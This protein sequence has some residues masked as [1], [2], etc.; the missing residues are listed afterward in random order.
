MIGAEINFWL[1]IIGKLLFVIFVEGAL[2]FFW[3]RE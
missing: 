3:S 2:K 1:F